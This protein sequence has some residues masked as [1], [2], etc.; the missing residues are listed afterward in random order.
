M[1]SRD[2]ILKI[3]S[4]YDEHGLKIATICS[5]SALQIFHGARME[6]LE[7]LGIALPSTKPY[8]E[9]FS[10]AK[11]DDFIIVED[12][13]KILREDLQKRLIEENALI[14]PHGSFVEYVGAG[15]ILEKFYVPMF[16]NRLTLY[17][18]SDRERQYEWIMEAGLPHPKRY[19]SPEE[20]DKLVIVK[21]C[22]AKGGSGYF[23]TSSTS[24]FYS[25]IAELR[26][27]KIIGEDSGYI[28]EEFIPG[29]RLYP[30]FFFS[31]IRE[32]N[33]ISLPYGSL[34]ILGMD[35]RLEV[36]DEIHRGLPETIEDFLDFTVVG[37]TPVVVREKL[38]ID[39]LEMSSKIIQASRKLF[40]PGL[41]GPF[42]IEVMY[43]PEK[44]FKIFEISTRI[45]A[46]TNLYPY[47]SPYSYYYYN[48]PMSMGRRIAREIKEAIKIGKLG[49]LVY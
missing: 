23:K 1:I 22:G 2:E 48:E 19:Y 39:I 7:T 34:E 11:P 6:G 8:Y 31:P 17:W 16:G 18:E 26:R 38:I 41:I 29:V 32:P 3:L 25:K 13:R 28:I 20:I 40:H 12:Y 44:G 4:K 14:I 5:H 42:C 37:N 15:N 9:S 35:R 10:L 46:G 27:K 43:H 49:E 21:L 45:V 33:L 36:I 47:G 30:H 24:E